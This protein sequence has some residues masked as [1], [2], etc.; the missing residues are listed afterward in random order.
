MACFVMNQVR[1]ALHNLLCIYQGF[2]GKKIQLP[3]DGYHN[4]FNENRR[5]S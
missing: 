5:V 2:T 3:L 4:G 1:Q